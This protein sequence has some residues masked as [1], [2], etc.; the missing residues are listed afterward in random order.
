MD[1]PPRRALT[2]VLLLP[3]LLLHLACSAGKPILLRVDPVTGELTVAYVRRS[4]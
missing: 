1:R 4:G 2:F 3:V